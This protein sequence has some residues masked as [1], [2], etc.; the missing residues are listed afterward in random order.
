MKPHWLIGLAMLPIGYV[1]RKIRKDPQF[2]ASVAQMAERD[3][4]GTAA[5]KMGRFRNLDKTRLQEDFRSLMG[6]LIG[7]IQAKQT[8]PTLPLPVAVTDSLLRP[9][10]ATDQLTW[11]GHSAVRLESGGNTVLFDPMLG[12]WVAPVPFLGHRFPYLDYHPLESIGE[13]DLIVYSHDH[14]DHLDYD[15]L[16]A[17]RDRTAAYLV[18]LGMGAHL[19]HWGIPDDK[20]TELD[21]WQSATIGGI[22]YTATPA[23]H[24]SGR[25]PSTRNKTLWCSFVIETANHKL[26]FGGDSGYGQHFRE[27]GRRYGPFDLTM[28]D[29][30]QY[31]KRWKN[32]HMQPEEALKANEELGGRHVMP[33]HWGGF[34][35]SDHSW[36]DPI[37]RIMTADTHQRAIS[38]MIGQ[39]FNVAEAGEYRDHWWEAITV[40]P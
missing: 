38:P 31:H 11:Y 18:P 14:Y 37:D 5:W 15:T 29:S 8:Q 33:I 4:Q 26:Y 6:D 22:T 28:L 7:Y 12:E 25:S 24:F 40:R 16:M 3:Y 13:I 21:W 19:R 23:R 27:I 10:P 9:D 36:Y 35:L 17:V 34:S 1:A 20:I 30:G 2:G 39:R 32:V